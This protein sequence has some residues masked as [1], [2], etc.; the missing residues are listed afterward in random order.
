MVGSCVSVTVTVK[1][2]VLLLPAASVTRKVL[3]VVPTGNEAPEASPVVWVVVDPE[4]LSVPTGAV[5]VT[6]AAHCPVI[7]LTLMLAGQ[8]MEGACA[9][10]TVTVKLQVAVLAEASVTRKVLVVTPTGNEAPD[11]KPA[12][13]VVVGPEQLSVPTGVV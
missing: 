8:V 10:D 1:A 12:V 13:W 6:F 5:K 11:A 9:S 3:V 2:Q 4:Q 7:L